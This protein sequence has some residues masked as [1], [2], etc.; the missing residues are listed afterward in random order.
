MLLRYQ[1]ASELRNDSNIG[2]DG[3]VH[4]GDDEAHVRPAFS[5]LLYLSLVGS[6]SVSLG[7][8]TLGLNCVMLQDDLR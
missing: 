8:M 3:A 5:N 6:E 4:R 1:V 7:R 2:K